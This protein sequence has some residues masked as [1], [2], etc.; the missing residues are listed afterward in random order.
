MF[1]GQVVSIHTAAE[2]GGPIQDHAQIEAVAH[3]GL[4]GDRNFDS[5]HPEA[6]V[7]LIELE[8]IEALA[9]DYDIALNPAD[10]RRNIVTKDVPLNHLVGKTFR[11]GGVLMRGMELCEPCNYLA[12]KT[13][14]RVL[15]ALVHRGGL[16]AAILSDGT[17]RVGD[18][19]QPDEE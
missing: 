9:R 6:A 14:R 10:S 12:G 7:T 15:P 1:R 17:I 8:S 11:V 2:A 16:R 13:Q 5:G 19:V 18:A 4:R 3:R